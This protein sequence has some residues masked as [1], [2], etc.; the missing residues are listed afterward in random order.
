MEHWE[1]D[2]P[3]ALALR[4]IKDDV[5]PTHWHASRLLDTKVK[6]EFNQLMLKSDHLVNGVAAPHFR[7]VGVL[8]PLQVA[9][10]HLYVFKAFNWE[11]NI[12]AN[13]LRTNDGFKFSVNFVRVP[14]PNNRVIIECVMYENRPFDKTPTVVS[15]AAEAQFDDPKADEFTTL[16][17]CSLVP[18]QEGFQDMRRLAVEN[19]WPLVWIIINVYARPV[20]V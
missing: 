3:R 4:L 6:P 8:V 1:R 20:S 5:V 15:Y 10:P 12:T 14:R 18:S 16:D 7:H 13:D 9:G 19:E 11:I 17:L 2:A